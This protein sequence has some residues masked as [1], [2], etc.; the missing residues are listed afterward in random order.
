MHLVL[1][2]KKGGSVRVIAGQWETLNLM[3]RGQV[4]SDACVRVMEEVGY[5]VGYHTS[6]EGTK[7]QSAT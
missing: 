1:V 6:K 3:A 5:L 2:L 4:P 7:R